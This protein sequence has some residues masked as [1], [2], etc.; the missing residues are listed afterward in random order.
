MQCQSKSAC[1]QSS[2]TGIEEGGNP[3]QHLHHTAK[4]AWP[5]GSDAIQADTNTSVS[6]VTND[7]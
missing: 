4:D 1:A 3:Y 6:T 7:H 2:S 5:N